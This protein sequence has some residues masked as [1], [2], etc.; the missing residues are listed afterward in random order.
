MTIHRKQVFTVIKVILYTVC[1]FSVQPDP[2]LTSPSGNKNQEAVCFYSRKLLSRHSWQIILHY[3]NLISAQNSEQHIITGHSA[4]PHP[5][6]SAH[7]YQIINQYEPYRYL[8]KA[9]SGRI[10]FRKPINQMT[11]AYQQKEQAF[12]KNRQKRSFQTKGIYI[13]AGSQA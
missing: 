11:C 12:T 6:R 5:Y 13:L 4:Q 2:L 9:M 7:A 8:Q 10:F 3:R 1:R